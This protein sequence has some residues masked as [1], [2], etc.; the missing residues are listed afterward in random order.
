MTVREAEQLAACSRMWGVL[1]WMPRPPAPPSMEVD[2]EGV[3]AAAAWVA[4]AAS[5]ETRWEPTRWEVA[6]TREA[7]G[8]YFDPVA[9]A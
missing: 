4:R 5:D 2:H 7:I 8:A 9:G 1:P 3:L 6:I